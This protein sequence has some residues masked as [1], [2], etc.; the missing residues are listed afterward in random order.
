MLLHYLGKLSIQIFCRYSADTEENANK[1]HFECTDFN[2]SMRVAVWWVSLCI[3]CLMYFKEY[4]KYLS[5]RRHSYFLRYNV[6]G[7]DK[8][9]LLCG[10]VWWLWKEPVGY[11]VSECS[12][13]RPFALTQ[14]RSRSPHSSMASSMNVCGMLDQVSMRRRLKSDVSRTTV[15]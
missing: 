8:S 7:S 3:Y 4:L 5:I 2:S 9:W 14:A 1:V 10:S 12:K 11:S 13:W 15:L 6:G